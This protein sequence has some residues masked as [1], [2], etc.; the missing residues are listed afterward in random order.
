MCVC[1]CV[2]VCVFLISCRHRIVW[3]SFVVDLVVSSGMACMCVCGGGGGGEGVGGRLL[4][5][6]FDF[7][8]K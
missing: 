7:V 1:V 6:I 8:F 3:G 2:C 5:D 4:F